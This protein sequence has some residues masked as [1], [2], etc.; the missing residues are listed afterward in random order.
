MAFDLSAARDAGYSDDEIVEFL[1]AGTGF[2]ADAA[3]ESGYTTEEILEHL[4]ELAAQ[5]DNDDDSK[6]IESNE[7]TQDD[8][9]D[10]SADPPTPEQEPP[11]AEPDTG[12]DIPPRYFKKVRV[13][14]E[15]F[16]EDERKSETHKVSA[17]DALASIKEDLENYKKLLQCMKGG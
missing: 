12:S 7:E 14:H 11:K 17:K 16:I 10:V 9:D 1:S 6:V 15:I 4:S 5:D 8:G 2:D 13:D 3:L